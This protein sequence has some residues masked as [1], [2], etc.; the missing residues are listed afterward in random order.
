MFALD[1]SGSVGANE[2]QQ[3]IQFVTTVILSMTLYSSQTPN[4][5]QIGL[6]TFAD[7]ATAE[8][9]LNTYTDKNLLLS[10]V[11]VPYR[12]GQTNVASALRYGESALLITAAKCHTW[13]SQARFVINVRPIELTH[14]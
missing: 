9:Y 11:Y 8:F 12:R 13:T 1:A 6:I 10:A 7:N 2:F 14:A 4:G 5:N 3:M